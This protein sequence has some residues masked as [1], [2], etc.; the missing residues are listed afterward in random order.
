MKDQIAK[1]TTAH[2]SGAT[3]RGIMDSSVS[4]GASQRAPRPIMGA[5]DFGDTTPVAVPDILGGPDAVLPSIMGS[6]DLASLPD[7][8][9]PRGGASDI[10]SARTY[11]P[12]VSV[13]SPAVR[14][15]LGAAV[16]QS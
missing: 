8:M 7:I 12:R 10:M 9:G 4:W 11:L 5:V 14:P 2:R 13:H 1:I 16:G 6:P 3:P 15:A